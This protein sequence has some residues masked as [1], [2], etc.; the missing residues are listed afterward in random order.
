MKT[1]YPWQNES[2]Q[3]LQGLRT[4]LPNALL[5]KGAKGIGKLELAL[6]FAQSLL[7]Q[8]STPSGMP[9]ETCPAC[10]WFEQDSH[11]DFRLIQPE[12]LSQSDDAL[13]QVDEK[14][15][16][17]KKPSQEISVAQIRALANFTNLSAHQGGY[18]VVVIHPAESMN[19][20]SANALLKTLEEPTDQ[21]LFILVTHKPQQLL[22]TILSRCLSLT[23]PIPAVEVS[24]A[25][26]TQQGVKNPEAALAHAGFS[27][28]QSL[29][30]AGAQE[31]AK[32]LQDL[33]RALQQPE[34]LDVI[35]VADA[36]QRLPTN[37]FVNYLAKWCYDL[38]S[39]SLTGRVRYFTE[40]SEVL[41][42]LSSK[43]SITQQLQYQQMLKIAQ[44]EAFHPLNAK[45]QFEALL[46]A[47]QHIFSTR[48]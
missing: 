35:A 48:S 22:A 7:C 36:L 26:L 2:W 20:N 30:G 39:V 34:Q 3:S 45:L 28:L 33:L 6:I 37:E 16:G 21:L 10:H 11:P 9:C 8:K 25:W 47:Y 27:P 19:D 46:F 42:K 32:E 17:K 29:E 1:L 44:R 43:A 15:E 40:H 13:N 12:A 5:L 23:I 24:V 31:D 14:K 4:R 18:R 38:S 41:Q